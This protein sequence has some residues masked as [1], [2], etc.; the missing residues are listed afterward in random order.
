[1]KEKKYIDRLY[2]EK[3][4]DFEATP[5][6]AVWN[7]ISAKLQDK[8][9]KRIV[10][11]LWQ[12]IA[13][14]AA[15]LTL[16]FLIGDWFSAPQQTPSVVNG[17]TLQNIDLDELI[18][19]SET[20]ITFISEEGE[21]EIADQNPNAEIIEE[22]NQPISSIQEEEKPISEVAEISTSGIK[23]PSP[24]FETEAIIFVENESGLTAIGIIE[25]K[26]IFDEILKM[27]EENE[28]KT[29]TSSKN[30]LEISTSAAP[31]FFGNMGEGSFLDPKFNN[32]ESQSEIT[33][34]YGI[35]LAYAISE[36]LKIRS[37]INQVSMSYNTNG[38][39]YQAV[40]RPMAINSVNY[41]N[42]QYDLPAGDVHKGG[43]SSAR[44]ITGMYR[45][46]A[47]SINGAFLNQKLGYLEVPVELEYSIINNKIQLNLIGGA[48][49]MFLNE[50]MVSV[51]TGNLT[52]NIGEAN[53]LNNVSFSTNI[54]LGLDYKLF[55][56]FNVNLEPMF[57]YQINT[58][59]GSAVNNQP[60]YL[61]IYTGFSFEF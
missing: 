5:N 24:Q 54:G 21:E 20:S 12:R 1:M 3:F 10:F 46:S 22:T 39:T 26:S 34:S 30:K 25:K 19:S 42:D 7:S 60:Y 33:Y 52:T 2:Q 48:S 40:L 4:K 49:T 9:Q 44:P 58:F 31:V 16:I 27:Q 36:N 13:G 37:G 23:E 51:N 18:P 53:N 59:S 43:N 50:N 8:K 47:G 29:T 17:N 45:V 55:E 11:P 41:G 35:Q 56:S 6:E 15:L 61:A 57:K 32:N 28:L 38:V 14:V